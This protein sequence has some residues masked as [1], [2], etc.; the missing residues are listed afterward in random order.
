MEPS[1]IVYM[2]RACPT[3]L[4]T[5]TPG[6]LVGKLDPELSDVGTVQAK[7]L[8]DRMQGKQFD[9]VYS[10]PK[11]RA[12]QTAIEIAKVQNIEVRFNCELDAPNMGMWEG[13]TWDDVETHYSQSFHMF[14]ADQYGGTF[15]GGDSFESLRA[16]ILPWLIKTGLRHPDSRVLAVTHEEVM[17]ATIS[18]VCGLDPQLSREMSF[19]RGGFLVFRLYGQDPH[20][21][22]I[23]EP[24]DDLEIAEIL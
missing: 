13:K 23:H 7:D 12:A 6:I 10:S 2:V 15:P 14:K 22:S 24:A 3:K 21:E 1:A 5:K 16:K 8:A 19:P 4:D 17:R 11:L 9:A 20:L 18:A